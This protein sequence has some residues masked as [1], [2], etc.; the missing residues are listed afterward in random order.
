MDPPI[1][2]S[3]LRVFIFH[4]R[5]LFF[6]KCIIFPY[7]CHDDTSYHEM[8]RLRG[9]SISVNTLNKQILKLTEFA[10][11][12]AIQPFYDEGC[13]I[14]DFENGVI[15]NWTQKGEAFRQQPTYGDTIFLREKRRLT[16]INGKW[17]IS[18]IEIH[19]HEGAERR[20]G[21]RSLEGVVTSPLFEISSTKISFLIGGGTLDDSKVGMELL[22]RGR[23]VREF[24]IRNQ[25]WE[26]L[27]R[28][29]MDVSEFFRQPA[30]IRLFDD[31]VKGYLMFDDL[32]TVERCKDGKLIFIFSLI[33][34]E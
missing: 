20:V 27:Q 16:G 28:H 32:R 25:Q 22:V 11:I 34:P 33:W 13:P 23:K 7:G 26:T 9:A 10:D 12:Q 17:W 14:F 24:F 18:S 2:T 19:P 1:V 8:Q 30:R 4:V 5:K 21:S 15:S 31:S 3:N 29:E 6:T